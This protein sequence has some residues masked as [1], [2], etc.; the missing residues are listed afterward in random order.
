MF[1]GPQN[2]AIFEG[3]IGFLGWELSYLQPRYPGVDEFPF[4]VVGHA[5]VPW[6]VILGM[7]SWY[8][9]G[10]VS[11]VSGSL[12]RCYTSLP[13]VIYFPLGGGV[14]FFSPLWE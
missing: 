4:F 12:S 7:V 9:K 6:R 1:I 10:G 2:D 5:I 8:C 3:E 14:F 13:H 11:F